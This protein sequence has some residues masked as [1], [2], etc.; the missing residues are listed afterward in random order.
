MSSEAEQFKHAHSEPARKEP[1]RKEPL[2]MAVVGLGH[3][4]KNVLRSFAATERCEVRAICDDN[5]EL[6]SRYASLYPSAKSTDNFQ[7]VLDDPHTD[8]VAIVT[9]AP[10]HHQM[11]TRALSAG[12][13]VFVEKPAALTV[14]HAQEMVELADSM[15]RKLMVGHLLEYHPAVAA[16]KE[17]IDG[18]C[19]GDVHYMYS[20]RLNLGIVRQSENAFW[21]LAPHDISVILYLFGAEPD[22]VS[23]SGAS[24]LQNGIEDVVFAN[25]HFPD[26]RIAQIHVSWLDPHKARKMVVVGSRKMM[27]FDDMHPSEKIRIFDKGANVDAGTDSPLQAITVRHGDIHVPH[28]DGRPPL[29]I[30]TA[31]FVDCIVNDRRPRSDGRDGLRVVRVLEQVER[32]LHRPRVAQFRVPAIMPVSLSTEPKPRA[33]VPQM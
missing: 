8:A 27:V 32:H 15:D 25:L 20:Q 29:D 17:Q 33:A 2:R 9:P 11:A 3:W 28:I 19:L 18:R 30:E 1:A 31:H 24:F 16:M 23:A 13:H 21:S 22:E 14:D 26:G 6:L 12:K 5:P 10:L 7:S 4:G